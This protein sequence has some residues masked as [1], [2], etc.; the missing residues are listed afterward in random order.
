MEKVETVGSER[1]CDYTEYAEGSCSL[2]LE[3]YFSDVPEMRIF[4][5]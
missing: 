1:K 5:C 2:A 3:L 4:T